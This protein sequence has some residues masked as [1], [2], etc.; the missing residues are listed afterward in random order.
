MFVRSWILFAI[1]GLLCLFSVSVVM[2]DKKKGD[3]N[4]YLKR[5]GAKFIDE[6]AKKEGII[7]LKSGM[8]VEILKTSDKANAKSPTKSDACKVTYKGTLKD[9]TQFDAGTTSFAPNQVIS[10]WTEAMQLMGEG[11]HWRLYI[12]Y[13]LA[14]GERGSP[15]RIPAFSPLVFE[16][17]IHEVKSGGKPISEAR[18]MF[19]EAKASPIEEL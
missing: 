18:K 2:A 6:T 14:Y 5:T 7:K 9:G 1:F 3:P 10:G 16:L 11:D 8:L 4:N 12:P 15:P 17:E 19:E 13:N